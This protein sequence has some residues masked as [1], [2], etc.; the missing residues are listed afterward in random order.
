MGEPSQG[1]PQDVGN[2]ERRRYGRRQK[3][4]EGDSGSGNGPKWPRI[5]QKKKKKEVVIGHKHVHNISSGHVVN[6]QF[7]RFRLFSS[8]CSRDNSSRHNTI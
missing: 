3:R 8:Q 5:N 1:W 4:M 2:Y 6:Y 7:N